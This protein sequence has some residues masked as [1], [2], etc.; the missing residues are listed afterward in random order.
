MQPTVS[1]HLQAAT[2]SLIES[3]LASEV[4]IRYRQS[5]ARL[6]ADQEACSLLEQLTQSQ[7]R[8]RQK[9]ANG[10]VTQAEIDDLR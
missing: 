10:G 4:F 5:Y 2:Q 1:P 9:Q 8:L 6:N 7:V 3:L